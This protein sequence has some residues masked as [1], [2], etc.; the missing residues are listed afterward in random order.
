MAEEAVSESWYCNVVVAVPVYRAELSE[1]EKSSFRQ[2]TSVLGK[3]HSIVLFAPEGI[4]LTL[5][6]EIFPDFQV[7]YFP[8]H[9]FGSIAD[10][11][12]LLLSPDF[13]RRFSRYEWMLICQ[14]DVWVLKDNLEYWCQQNYDYIGAPIPA[15]WEFYPGGKIYDIVG[16]GGFS[17][18][19]I[20]SVIRVLESDQAKMFCR[21]DLWHFFL[22]HCR[23]FHFIRALIPLIRMTGIGNKRKACLEIMRKKGRSEDMVFH[24]LS[25]PAN[26]PYLKIPSCEIAAAFALDGNYLEKFDQYGQNPPLGIH[27]F[28]KGNIEAFLKKLKKFEKSGGVTVSVIVPVYNSESVLSETLECVL[29]Q[30]FKDWECIIVNDGSTDKSA[31]IAEKYCALDSRFMLVKQE[32]RGVASARNHG[33]VHASGKYLLPLDSDDIIHESYMEKAVK[34]L[35]ENE[36]VSLVYC[37]G[38]YC[39]DAEGKEWDLQPYI[40]Y[41]SLLKKN[42]IFVS[43]FFRKKDFLR[44]KG[45]NEELYIGE[46]WEFLIRL[47]EGNLQVV[48]LDET[49]FFYRQW[50]SNSSKK[51]SSQDWAREYDRVILMHW[52]KYLRYHFVMCCRYL[53]H[54]NIIEPLKRIF[55]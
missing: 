55:K 3:K 17:L 1:T 32:N 9:C 50:E 2:T 35:E 20:A 22:R 13:Y 8:P 26:P 23:R 11:S 39:G 54:Y 10:Y 45:Y 42:N 4:D 30:S 6:R 25:R 21:S 41:K 14:L 47:L 18:R 38:S 16:N 46:D 7:E 27:A 53:V 28:H 36:K 19:R 52:K 44:I 37:K 40:N 34:I 5:Y 31:E 29:K 24:L 43:V 48:Q 15:S 12:R 51:Y 49:L 33:A